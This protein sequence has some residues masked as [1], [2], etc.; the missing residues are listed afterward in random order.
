MIIDF[1][2]AVRLTEILMAMAF[3]HQSLEHLWA[4]KSL[5]PLFLA[6]IF[7]CIA[8]IAGFSLASVGLFFVALFMLHH[9]QGPYNG[10][11][12]RMSLLTLTCITFVHILPDEQ[13]QHYA[14][15]YLAIQLI[16]SYL[17][18]GW[19]KIVNPE[20]RDG[21]ALI[22]VFTFSIYPVSK[23]TRKWVKRPRLLFIASWTVMIFE[24]LFPLFLIT[25]TMLFVG[26]GLAA[27][28][29]FANHYLFGFNRFFW[30]WIATYPSLIWLQ[31]LL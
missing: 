16:L 26:L 21:R 15:G 25:Q 31:S 3:I 5:R 11:S 27:S 12:D 29:H 24:L 23:T 19:V 17:I 6:R 30:I 13:W 10:G 2:S 1:D 8:L 22:D 9:F 28:F 20:W 14:F 7:L 18:A 4:T